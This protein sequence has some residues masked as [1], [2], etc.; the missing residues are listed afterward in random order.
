MMDKS[1]KIS[2]A[3][4][5]SL[6]VGM[7][8]MISAF[9]FG[10]GFSSGIFIIGALVTAFSL[11]ELASLESVAWVSWIN[12]ILGIWL[13][14]SP[15]IAVSSQIGALWNSIVMGLILIVV[16]VWAGMASSIIGRGH[17]RMG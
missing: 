4:W 2:T 9:L 8:L 12:G 1:D 10:V 13:M 14:I 11:I 3:A 17:P 6:V 16:S 5:I 7:W 15:F